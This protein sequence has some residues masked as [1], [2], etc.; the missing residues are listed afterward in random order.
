M[1]QA[2]AFGGWLLTCMGL[3]GVPEARQRRTDL[4]RRVDAAVGTF[5]LHWLGDRQSDANWCVHAC[6]RCFG[7]DVSSHKGDYHDGRVCCGGGSLQGGICSDSAL[8]STLAPS[9]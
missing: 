6:L 2:K 1:L 5:Y 7:S 8:V 4:R 3:V 9:R